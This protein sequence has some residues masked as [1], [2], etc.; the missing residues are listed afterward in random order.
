MH[1]EQ[2]ELRQQTATVSP[3]D[4]FKNKFQSNI[5]AKIILSEN[6]GRAESYIAWH[7]HGRTVQQHYLC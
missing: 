3:K 6:L 2:T 7:W 4:L 5:Y 1:F